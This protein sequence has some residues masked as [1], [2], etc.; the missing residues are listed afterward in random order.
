MSRMLKEEQKRNGGKKVKMA[1]REI[2]PD[3]GGVIIKDDRGK[4]LEHPKE[5]VIVQVGMIVFVKRKY[6]KENNLD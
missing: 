1:T 6:G 3:C 4:L 5:L 2:C